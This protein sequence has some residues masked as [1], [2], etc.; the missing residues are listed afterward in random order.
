MAHYS[1]HLLIY[2][3]SRGRERWQL[4]VTIL[5]LEFDSVDG[6]LYVLALNSFYEGKIEERVELEGENVEGL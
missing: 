3:A 1:I 4:V 5:Y 2:S 6:V